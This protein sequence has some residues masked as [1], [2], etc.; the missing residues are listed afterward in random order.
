MSAAA[1]QIL[2]H[3]VTSA[4]APSYTPS[5]DDIQMITEDPNYS[6]H[7]PRP[8]ANEPGTIAQQLAAIEVAI[9]LGDRRKT[10]ARR[11]WSDARKL[12][13]PHARSGGDK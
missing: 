3:S 6:T 8:A 10:D 5:Q 1:S 2:F 4:V 12:V 7:R 13:I 11:E 9:Y